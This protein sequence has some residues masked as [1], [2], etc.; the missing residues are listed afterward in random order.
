MTQAFNILDLIPQ[1]PP[2]VMVDTLVSCNEQDTF[3]SFKIRA[4]NVFCNA[5][6]FSEAGLIENI[7]QT[8][9]ARMGYLSK[10]NNAEVKIGYIGAIKNISIH[11][12]PNVNTFLE[13]KVSVLSELMGFTIIRGDIFCE[14]KL[15]ATCEMRIFLLQ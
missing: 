6:V 3:S 13:T 15:A 2:M 1:R 9:A 5:N 14:N 7:A 12:L 10:I 8:A 4:D 11:F